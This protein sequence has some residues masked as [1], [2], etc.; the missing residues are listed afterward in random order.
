MEWVTGTCS[1]RC[2]LPFPTVV[3]Q[4]LW[5]WCFT[6][7]QTLPQNPILLALPLFKA[8]THFYLLED[9]QGILWHKC[10]C[11]H[12][13]LTFVILLRTGRLG[14]GAY[15]SYST[16]HSSPA[17]CFP[18]MTL[19][20]DFH[21]WQCCSLQLFACCLLF[22]FKLMSFLTVFPVFIEKRVRRVVSVLSFPCLCWSSFYYWFL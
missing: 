2:G 16:L 4:A 1:P 20:I 17:E 13:C 3:S 9:L 19:V 22:L 8:W 10:L 14:K 15:S 5:G 7:A 18:L 12:N 6:S 21:F 11:A